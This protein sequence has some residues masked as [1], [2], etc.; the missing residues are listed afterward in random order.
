MLT[1]L[2]TVIFGLRTKNKEDGDF[3]A[4]IKNPQVMSVKE[5]ITYRNKIIEVH[6][7]IEEYPRNDG[8]IAYEIVVSSKDQIK[9]KE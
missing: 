9:I 7:D 1:A 6:G 5:A 3:S 4:F 8:R 2:V